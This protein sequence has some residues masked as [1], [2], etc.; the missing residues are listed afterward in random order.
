MKKKA[1]IAISIT[2]ALFIVTAIIMLLTA[3]V[4]QNKDIK[5]K[6]D[7]TE[8]TQE[9]K[10][11][12]T[13]E[14][15]EKQGEQETSQ[16]IVNIE[17]NDQTQ[18]STE[19]SAHSI[20]PEVYEWPCGSKYFQDWE[21]PKL[22]IEFAQYKEYYEQ[23]AQQFLEYEGKNVEFYGDDDMFYFDECKN[24]GSVKVSYDK[25]TMLN[26]FEKSNIRSVHVSSDWIIF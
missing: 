3:P 12:I 4:H 16:E 21:E 10:Q 11:N 18:Q 2:G 24:E 26:L 8:I 23:M 6:K 1:G 14:Q 22:V 20:N 7:I 9:E 13:T 15:Q 19:Q 17:K 25:E 5:D